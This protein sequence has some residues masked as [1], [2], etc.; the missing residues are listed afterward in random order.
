V[1]MGTVMTA[2][3]RPAIISMLISSSPACTVCP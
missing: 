2:L 3:R 1:P